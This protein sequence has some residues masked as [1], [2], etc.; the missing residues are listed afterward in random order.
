MHKKTDVNLV[1]TVTR[2]ETGQMPRINKV[3][4]RQVSCIQEA[5]CTVKSM[6]VQVF[7][8]ICLYSY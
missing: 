6:Q 1:F 3:F 5:H 7:K 2:P 8:F 4:E